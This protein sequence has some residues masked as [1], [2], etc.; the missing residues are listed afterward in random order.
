MTPEP[1]GLVLQTRICMQ[2][3]DLANHGEDAYACR[4]WIQPIVAVLG[5]LAHSQRIVS[6]SACAIGTFLLTPQANI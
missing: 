5:W 6:I 1:H 4:F 3:V 2:K